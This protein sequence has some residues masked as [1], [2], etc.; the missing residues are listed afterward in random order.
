MKYKI[1]EEH[2]IERL[3]IHSFQ[4]RINIFQFRSVCGGRKRREPEKKPESK[5]RTKYQQNVQD[6][7]LG[8]TGDR[9]RN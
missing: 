3:I 2:P 7:K 4:I 8:H 9:E 1:L 6:S 5:T